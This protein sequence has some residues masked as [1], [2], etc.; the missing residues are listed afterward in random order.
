MLRNDTGHLLTVFSMANRTDFPAAGLHGGQ[1]GALREHQLEGVAV[2][3]KSRQELKPGDRLLLL[4]A[5]G[6]GIGDPRL[7]DPDA[8]RVDIEN[9]FV[10]R[11]Q[12]VAVYGLDL[13]QQ[14]AAAD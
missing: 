8:V 7:R 3:P 10:S 5:G 4:E 12:A 6:G 1:A 2:H 11:A 14:D 13:P 9:G